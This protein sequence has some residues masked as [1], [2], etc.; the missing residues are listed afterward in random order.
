MQS[1]EK[2]AISLF[3][4]NL[5][6]FQKNHRVTYEKI[7]ILNQSIADG[8]YIEKYSLEYNDGYFDILELKS[9][10]Y[11]YNQNSN[12]YSEKLMQNVN[13]KKSNSVVEGFYE[14][15]E[16]SDKAVEI[17]DS[18][19]NLKNSLFASAKII[20]YNK[21]STSKNDEM[22]NISKYIYC[23]VGLGLHL[24]KIQK[25]VRALVL[26]IIE[27]NLEVFRLSLF[28]TDYKKLSHNT[29]LVFSIMD[30]KD[31]FD[32][33]NSFLLKESIYNNY[34]KYTTLSQNNISDIKKVQTAIVKSMHQIRP[35]TKS[36]REFLKAPEY[37]V[38]NYPFIN[39]K[40][41]DKLFNDKPIL[42]IA[43]GPSLDY[44][45]QWLQ[46]NQH[47]FI[48]ISVFSSIKTLHEF[49]IKPNIIV[50]IDS[51][52]DDVTFLNDI[53]INSFFNQT[54]FLFSSVVARSVVDKV[55]KE[56]LYFF[57]SASKYKTSSRIPSV[58]S[59][60]ETAYFFSL[61]FGVKALYLL[62]LDLALDPETKSNHTIGHKEFRTLKD[63]TKENEHYTSLQDTIIYT[64]GNFLSEVPTT[65]LYQMSI[66]AFVQISKYYLTPDCKVFNLSNG[67]FLEGS[68]AQKIQTIDTTKFKDINKEQEF[69]KI[70][71][72][73]SKISQ[74]SLDKDEMSKFTQQIEEAK[75]VL[76][77]IQK[78]EKN[79]HV[80]NY[81]QY[82]KYF[83]TLY[84]DLLN[85]NGDANYDISSVLYLYIQ[86][87]VGYIFDILNTKN[88]YNDKEYIY[89]IN[90]I[91]LKQVKK[92]VNLYI[93]TMEIYL[94]WMRK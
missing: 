79:F 5:Q 29:T 36:L 38:E 12:N 34:I 85:V 62:G 60:G 11:L 68:I 57:E 28:T 80:E 6:Y 70:Q 49:N 51:E 82:L 92:I 72:F 48:I 75:R 61:I 37:I 59:I 16:V 46:E 55:P 58:P 47:K 78:C 20:Q 66:G 4:S 52:Y 54:I 32:A 44:N 53:N 35:Y 31:Q 63:T 14:T 26:L 13:Y 3:Q 8:S 93:T 25:K 23:G 10:S 18:T 56:Q 40:L 89:D 21:K 42:L 87:V 9:N 27:N 88:I 91:F 71:K 39:L 45:I 43:S 73:M 50:H 22:Q 17:L 19:V 64:K 33:I 86:N 76:H 84:I 67:A 65:A 41:N 15:R 2:K 7:A 90:S 77:I 1:I 24:S 69:K 81:T 94:E 74:N 30:D 83:H